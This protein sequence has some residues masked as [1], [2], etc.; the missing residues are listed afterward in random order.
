MPFRDRARLLDAIGH[1]VPGEPDATGARP[2]GHVEHRTGPI[3]VTIDERIR[4]VPLHERVRGIGATIIATGDDGTEEDRGEATR[5]RD[6]LAGH[7]TV[8]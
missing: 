5:H 3:D 8:T 6:V 1:P 7:S 4:G 2:D